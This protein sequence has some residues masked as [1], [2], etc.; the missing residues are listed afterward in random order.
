[1]VA[2]DPKTRTLTAAVRVSAKNALSGDGLPLVEGMFCRV[3]IPGRILEQ[4]VRLPRWAVSYEG[5]AY[6][7]RD[8]RLHTTR[9]RVAHCCCGSL[10]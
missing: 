2:F 9:V 3:E 7:V 6:V 10:G 4:V 8:Q 1:M 5:N